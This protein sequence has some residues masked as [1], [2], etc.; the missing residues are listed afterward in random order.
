MN[1]RVSFNKQEIKQ[2]K[3]ADFVS[4]M[5]E[6]IMENATIVGGV[7][8]A[9]ILVSVGVYFYQDSERQG[10]AD[11]RERYNNAKSQVATG[12]IQVALLELREIADDAKGT[13]VGG[14]ALF[15]M[16]TAN[17]LS[18]NY[19]EARR[20]FEAYSKSYTDFPAT[21]ASAVAGIAS[22]MESVSDY[23]GAAAKYEEALKVAPD[24]PA[25]RDYA[26]GALRC[27]LL[28]GDRAA[29]EAVFARI[30]VEFWGDPV[31]NIATRLLAEIKP[32]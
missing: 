16:A 30:E 28:A 26:L 7:I 19:D 31:V 32:L 29:A 2:D 3:F 25:V 8:L 14:Q 13:D 12:N 9:V 24:G 6:S 27:Y 23:S 1:T 22:C 15:L 20:G 17:Y 21:H 11:A 4:Q 5:R 10:L 18:K